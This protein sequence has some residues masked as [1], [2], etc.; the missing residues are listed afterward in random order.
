MK[1]TQWGG[2]VGVSLLAL[3][4]LFMHLDSLPLFVYDEGRLA[5]S[6]LE[7]VQ[8]GN[9]LVTYYDGKPDLWSTKPPLLVWIQA[10]H[11]KA[12]GFNLLAVRLPSALAGLAT[13]LAIFS[14]LWRQTRSLIPSLAGSLVLLTTP[15]FVTNHA[16]RTGDYDALLTLWSTLFLI[17]LFYFIRAT[18]ADKQRRRLWLAMLFFTLGV[19]TKGIV[20]FL[21][22]PGLL[23]FLLASR[24][25]LPLLRQ[26]H[27]Y[28]SVLASIGIV[29]AYY[30]GREWAGP[31]YLE[32]VLQN[33]LG[34]RFL[35]VVEGHHGPWYFYFKNMWEGE[36]WPWIGFVPL[37]IWYS[38]RDPEKSRR[39]Q[40]AFFLWNA[41]SFLLILSVAQ[42]KLFWYIIPVYP[43]LALATGGVL[44][45]I[46]DRIEDSSTPAWL[47]KGLLLFGLFT[48]PF[49]QQILQS[50]HTRDNLYGWEQR[51][52]ADFMKE[53]K[54]WPSYVAV[55]TNYNSH[56]AF[57]AKVYREKGQDIT[58][59]Y[60]HELTPGDTILM[61]EDRARRAVDDRWATEP[62]HTWK[63]CGLYR[64][65]SK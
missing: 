18:A 64:V 8:N 41:L 48:I 1:K 45:V 27:F 55:E 58:R 34:G 19:L 4:P 23:L 6:A 12:L 52:Y 7:M 32:A 5:N 31:G 39:M 11:M 14:F 20:I 40:W 2:L 36:F 22:L 13:I 37:A 35:N 65:G 25:L 53:V 9:W 15:G 3:F 43:L 49:V 54:D 30:L 62:L 21:F 59:K 56:L 33:E 44:G 57:Y 10:L 26:S 16:T 38:F 60:P 29:A 63:N 50:Y 47:L 61:C 42:T 17:Q 24:N 46:V 51:Q 28:F